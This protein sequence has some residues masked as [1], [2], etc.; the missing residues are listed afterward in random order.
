MDFVQWKTYLVHPSILCISPTSLLRLF[1]STIVAINS[2]VSSAPALEDVLISLLI[3]DR[4]LSANLLVIQ[5]SINVSD[6]ALLRRSL[7]CF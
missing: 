5:D 1:S 3:T 6:N 4:L 7:N 2:S